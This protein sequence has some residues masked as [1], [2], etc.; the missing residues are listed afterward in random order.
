MK[1]YESGKILLIGIDGASWNVITPMIDSGLLPNLAKLIKE[2]TSGVLES[3]EPLISPAIWTSIASG[4]KPDKHGIKDFFV[5]SKE[6]Q[7]KRIWD[8]AEESGLS[9]G[10]FD[11]MATWPPRPVNGFMIPGPFSHGPDT[12][13]GQFRFIRELALEEKTN[14]SRGISKYIHY[15]IKG[16]KN[17]IGIPTLLSAACHV[18]ADKIKIY[19]VLEKFYIQRKLRDKMYSNL[20]LSLFKKYSPDFT[21]YATNLTD[22]VQHSFW[23][24]HEHAGYENISAYELGMYKDIIPKAYIQVDH[25]IGRIIHLIDRDT[26]IVVVSDHGFRGV[27]EDY[28]KHQK[29]YINYSIN[30]KEIVKELSL[31]AHAKY[32][33]LGR[34]S[35]I[36]VNDRGNI[37]AIMD[38]LREIIVVG[39]ESISWRLFDVS[40]DDYLNINIKLNDSLEELEDL[41]KMEVLF[42]NKKMAFTD[43]I[44]ITNR[45]S[46]DHDK[47]GVLIMSGR[48]IKACLKVRNAS[49]LD[50]TPTL[51]ALL[52]LP[53][54]RDMDG[55]V[56]LEAID[57]RFLK[58]SPVTSIDSWEDKDY[59]PE[60]NNTGQ[61][62]NM[63]ERV[64]AKLSELGYL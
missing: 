13:P 7:C 53:V 49:V 62:S 27:T 47:E 2:G 21:I 23:K 8:M 20:F 51:L 56:I 63:E 57:E 52:K 45:F 12:Y 5:T 28:L 38:Q 44:N 64:K 42:K 36:R 43:I 3:I 34:R 11:Y 32:F 14:G 31:S 41:E 58:E 25:T 6:I 24:Y 9:V 33:N 17:G 60:N 18:L 15:G 46:G 22:A 37:D 30:I 29:K 10:V 40:L 59:S 4:K 35:F 1:D 61:D 39:P 16:L 55:R 26:T 50:I 48:N 54:G 19:E